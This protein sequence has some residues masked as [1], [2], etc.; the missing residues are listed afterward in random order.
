METYSNKD[1]KELL[2]EAMGTEE[3]K[4]ALKKIVEKHFP[5]ELIEVLSSIVDGNT[6]IDRDTIDEKINNNILDSY[7]DGKRSKE[8]MELL[9]K[10]DWSPEE[11]ERLK[12]NE[13]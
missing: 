13:R 3:G 2:T 4:D 10:G 6:Q 5:K 7:L 12:S 8:D 11:I 9:F 1:I